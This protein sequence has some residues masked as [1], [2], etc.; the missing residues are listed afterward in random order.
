MKQRLGLTDV[1]TFEQI[2]DTG[3]MRMS[4]NID[5]S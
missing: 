4:Q 1:E 3:Y 5:F 2:Q